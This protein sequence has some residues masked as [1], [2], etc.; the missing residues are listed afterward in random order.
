MLSPFS[1]TNP[2]TGPSSITAHAPSGG[3][4]ASSPQ[5]QPKTVKLSSSALLSLPYRLTHPPPAKEQVSSW[6]IVPTFDIKL[7]D[8]LDRKHLPPLGLK[9]FE[10]WLLFVEHSAENLY[11]ILWLREYSS[12]YKVWTQQLR[13]QNEFLESSS[14][15][16]RN[17]PLSTVKSQLP[18]YQSHP[19]KPFVLAPPSPSQ[20]TPTSPFSTGPG[21]SA[22]RR[23]R[24]PSP[25]PPPSPISSHHD[26]RAKRQTFLTPNGTYELDVPSPVLSVFHLTGSESSG[27]PQP[28]SQY[29]GYNNHQSLSPPPDPAVFNELQG[30]VEKKLEAS[31]ARFVSAT[32]HNVGN[33]RA[34]CGCVG[35]ATIG[36]ATST[37]PVI[38][39]FVLGTARWWRLFALPGLWLGMTIFLSAWYGVCM[40]IY[41][42]GDLRQL[43]SFELS[44]PSISSPKLLTSANSSNPLSRIQYPL[45]SE[46]RAVVVQQPIT[47]PPKVHIPG[48]NNGASRSN[49]RVGS[50]SI[51]GKERPVL[52]IV[53]PNEI[54]SRDH[55][56]GSVGCEEE[57][58]K[59]WTVGVEFPTKENNFSNRS[60]I[61][62]GSY[63]DYGDDGEENGEEHAEVSGHPRIAISDAFYDE[64]PSPEGPA[65]ISIFHERDLVNA[66]NALRAYGRPPLWPDYEEEGNATASFIH[67]YVYEDPAFRFGDAATIY[68]S[69]G[70]EEDVEAQVSQL[71]AQRQRVDSFDFDA[72]PPRPRQTST[73]S[74]IARKPSLAVNTDIFQQNLFHPFAAEEKRI[75]KQPVIHAG[76]GLKYFLGAIQTRCSPYDIVHQMKE[77]AAGKECESQREVHVRIEHMVAEKSTSGRLSGSSSPASTLSPQDSS[78]SKHS[79]ID[80]ET[81]SPTSLLSPHSIK[82]PSSRTSWRSSFKQIMTVPAF[83]SPLTPILNPVVGRAQWEIVVRSAFVAALLSCTVV[84]AL[85][86][87]P[88]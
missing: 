33:A 57:S 83:E 74:V 18:P 55:Q 15:S 65:T 42:F 32:F 48:Q 43:R 26:P 87:V 46:S 39:C 40:M 2:T 62:T 16:P 72:L 25:S 54:E 44:R 60:S 5:T 6:G 28:A 63:S 41:V 24:T 38:V 45:T 68:S 12:R 34:W 61:S 56:S 64:N 59:P 37:P 20:Q 51:E 11:F 17:I 50:C 3:H 86:G 4:A 7:Q 66:A 27:R 23:V 58:K 22:K 82:S 21:L 31:L 69:S 49:T 53:T 35:G 84:G 13:Q 79:P 88:T 1:N 47:R 67:P 77:A 10:E 73:S 70:T 85:L 30:I 14:S 8:I 36:L 52:R 78:S 76:S 80:S 9:D 81:T 71:A 19:N 29:T 75:I